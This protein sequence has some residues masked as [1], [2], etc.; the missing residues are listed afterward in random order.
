MT[1]VLTR[2]QRHRNMSHIRSR[3]TTPEMI[4][5]RGLHARGFRFRLQDRRLPGRPDLVL[6][7]YQAVIFVHGCFWHGHDCPIFR[8]PE[9][10]CDYWV[11]KINSNRNRDI[12]VMEALLKSGWRVAIVWECS[13]RGRARLDGETPV[14]RCAQFLR[15]DDRLIE[16]RGKSS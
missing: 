8:L 15:S 13:L 3:D 1:D 9:T 4:I 11:G 16:I 6:K 2:E 5:R 7:R 10:R 12:R 14:E